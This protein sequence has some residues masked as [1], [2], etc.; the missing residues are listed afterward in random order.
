VL[1]LG[2]PTPYVSMNG[3]IEGGF[4]FMLPVPHAGK[5]LGFWKTK[6]GSL[7]YEK[8]GIPCHI[9]VVRNAHGDDAIRQWIIRFLVI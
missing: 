4:N 1:E 5:M 6:L 3:N 2:A 8:V 9:A 7:Q